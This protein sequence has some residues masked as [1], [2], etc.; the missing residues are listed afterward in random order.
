MLLLSQV[1]IVTG[2]RESSLDAVIILIDMSIQKDEFVPILVHKT[3][4]AF[5]RRFVACSDDY[6]TPLSSFLNVP[7][8]LTA[9]WYISEDTRF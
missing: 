5:T 8:G 2:Y 7:T 3:V 9:Y 1:H 4:N 6:S